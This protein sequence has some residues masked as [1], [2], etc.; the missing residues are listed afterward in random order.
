VKISGGPSQAVVHGVMAL[1]T[2]IW[3]T[4]WA[5]VRLSLTGFPPLAGVAVRFLLAAAVLEVAARVVGQPLGGDRRLRWLW[6][7][8]A[9]LTFGLSYSIVY[10]AEQWVP[11][12]LVSVLFATFP[13]FVALFARWLLPAE[14]LGRLGIAGGVLGFLG[15]V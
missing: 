12:G 10:W 13:F 7:A 14:R 9:T 11:S 4:T 15:V 3:G 5:A 2:L 8:Q 6:L 1:L